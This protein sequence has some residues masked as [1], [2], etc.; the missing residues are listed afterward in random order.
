MS[1]EFPLAPVVGVGAVVFDDDGRILLVR[2]G[3]EPLLGEWSLPGGMLELGERIE[4]GIRREVREETGLD[5]V[6]EEIVTVFDHIAPTEDSVRIRFHY[7]L[8]DYRCRLLGGTL[9]SASD[10]TDA[11]WVTWD[12]LNG[13]GPFS[14]RPFT[15]S[16][17]RKALD[18]ARHTVH[19][20]APQELPQ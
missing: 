14:V 6:P 15:L 20:P 18:Q 10:A 4:D 11:R 3:Q 16:V 19:I 5:V 12:E 2:R 9:Q 13:H 17:I 8:I 1:R 7:V